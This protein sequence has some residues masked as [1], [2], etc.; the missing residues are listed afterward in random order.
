M[1]TDNGDNIRL[2]VQLL[3]LAH[4][5]CLGHVIQNGCDDVNK[6]QKVADMKKKTHALYIFFTEKNY[7]LYK[8]FISR[9]HDG[10]TPRKLP[11]L[12]PTRWWSELPLNNVLIK[13]HDFIREFLAY[14]D[15]GSKLHLI[16][17]A[18][19]IRFLKSYTSTLRSLEEITI[20]MSGEKYVTSSAILPVVYLVQSMY[21]DA[22]SLQ[23]EEHAMD[24]DSTGV[25]DRGDE[26]TFDAA[27]REVFFTTF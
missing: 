12:S 3:S 9:R 14:H 26:D 11:G 16:L 4:V 23:T 2:A 19:E 10:V 13:E 21:E 22:C 17:S 7:R 24:L 25:I 27:N 8:A 5:R 1:T 15:G 18:E 20:A 6:I